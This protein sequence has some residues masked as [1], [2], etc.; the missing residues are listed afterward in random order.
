MQCSDKGVRIYCPLTISSVDM[1]RLE[2][3]L[4]L[5]GG[6]FQLEEKIE[7]VDNNLGYQR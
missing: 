6:T 1:T 4:F 2:K 5:N 7:F 3:I